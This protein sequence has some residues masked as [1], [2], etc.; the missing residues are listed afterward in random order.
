[1]PLIELSDHD[2]NWRQDYEQARS[3]ILDATRG[4]V[5]EIEHVGG[6]AVPDLVARPVIDIAALIAPAT[7][8]EVELRLL[9]LNYGLAEV[10]MPGL[11]GVKLFR[12]PRRG[13]GAITHLVHLAVDPSGWAALLAVRDV[14]RTNAT[15]RERFAHEK[16]AVAASAGEDE[17]SY[18][19]Q[20]ARLFEALLD[21]TAS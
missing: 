20:K 7:R 12:R 13:F 6:T 8:G 10:E 14:L 18:A 11:P 1:M 21:R 19:A 5:L 2:P 17:R 3:L 9:G 15:E 4:R 16:S